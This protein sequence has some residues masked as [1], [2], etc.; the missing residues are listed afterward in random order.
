[1]KAFGPVPSRR[2]GRSVGINNI[3][4]KVCSYACIYCQV[5]S[6]TQLT[7]T[8]QAFYSPEEIF[9]EVQTKIDACRTSGE[10]IDYLT[11]VADGEPTLDIHLGDTID[12]LKPLGIDIAVIS[13]ASTIFDRDVQKELMRADWVS[14]KVDT[15]IERLWRK[16]NRPQRTLELNR[17]LEAIANFKDR[18]REPW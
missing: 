11:F 14:L 3:P 13:N 18:Y 16:I 6:T 12:L 4:V 9:R 8:R 7:A 5:G 17:I 1:M 15:P 2:L 10:P